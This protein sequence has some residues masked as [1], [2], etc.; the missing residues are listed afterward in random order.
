MK[1]PAVKAS[2]VP[3][4]LAVA[5]DLSTHLGGEAVRSQIHFGSAVLKL[6]SQFSTDFLSA[7]VF[8]NSIHPAIAPSVPGLAATQFPKVEPLV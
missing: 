3:V 6:Y 1:F 4:K 2:V 7:H 8:G 5:Q